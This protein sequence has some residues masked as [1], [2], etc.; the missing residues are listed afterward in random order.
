MPPSTRE[1]AAPTWPA[2]LALFASTG[3]LVCCALPALLVTLGLGAVT[4]GLVSAVP[5]LVWLSDHKEGVFA[6]SGIMLVAAGA[7]QWRTRNAP[8]PLDPAAAR[9][10]M[11]LRRLSRVLLG[12]AAAV[13]AVGFF[14]AFLAADIFYG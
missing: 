1:T 5:Q 14:F 9:A 6:V 2:I 11:R 3:T 12:V 10:C 4:A 7:M 8:C 13:Y